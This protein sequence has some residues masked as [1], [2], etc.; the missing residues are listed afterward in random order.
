MLIFC[1]GIGGGLMFLIF[2]SARHG[3]DEA[4]HFG[5]SHR[6]PPPPGPAREP[7]PTARPPSN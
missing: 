7:A 4:A 5:G 3:H 6:D 2:Y 1:F